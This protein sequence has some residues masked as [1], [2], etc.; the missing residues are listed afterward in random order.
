MKS[1]ISR[2][3]RLNSRQSSSIWYND[4]V[5]SPLAPMMDAPRATASSMILS[6]STITPRSTTSKPLQLRTMPVIFFPMS[7]TSPLTVAL[8]INGLCRLLSSLA[9]MCGSSTAT[10]SFIILADLTTCGRNIFPAPNN[11]PTFSM[12]AIRG[13]SITLTAAPQDERHSSTSSSRWSDRPL[14]RASASLSSTGTELL[15]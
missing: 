14:T 12:P 3:L 10:A 6:F 13:P 15:S 4:G 1:G 8:I 2:P 9:F 11:S 7:C 5:I